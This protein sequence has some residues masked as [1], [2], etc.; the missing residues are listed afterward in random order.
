MSLK[1]CDKKHRLDASKNLD[2]TLFTFDLKNSYD[3]L[4]LVCVKHLNFWIAKDGLN[5][6]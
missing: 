1:P 2:Q 6:P 4:K 3:F 5:S